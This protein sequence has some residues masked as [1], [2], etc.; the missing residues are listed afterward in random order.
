MYT[1]KDYKNTIISYD[2][3]AELQNWQKACNLLLSFLSQE[4]EVNKSLREHWQ[5]VINL[6]IS[7]A[8][9]GDPV[10]AMHHAQEAMENINRIT[11]NGDILTLDAIELC[12]SIYHS[13]GKLEHVFELYELSI[14]YAKKYFPD[15]HSILYI[16]YAKI[17]GILEDLGDFGA[18]EG[19][20]V[21][22]FKELRAL[23][24]DGV[25]EE[26]MIAVI[27]NLAGLYESMGQYSDSERFYNLALK[28]AK[29]RL[30][31]NHPEL[32]R[33]HNN[34]GYLFQSTG[35]LSHSSFH[36]GI[37]RDIFEANFGVINCSYIKASLGLSLTLFYQGDYNHSIQIANKI[38]S[39][40][41]NVNYSSISDEADAL[42]N[43]ALI[44][45]LAD[46]NTEALRLLEKSYSIEKAIYGDA[47]PILAK[48]LIQQ[49]DVHEN[50]GHYAKATKLYMQAITCLKGHEK[51]FN[52]YL[53]SAYNNIAHLYMKLNYFEKAKNMLTK[54][55][56]ISDKYQQNNSEIKIPFIINLATCN[57]QIGNIK[58]A[59]H[60][61]LNARKHITHGEGQ[62]R[63]YLYN[64]D[65]NLGSLYSKMGDISKAL[66]YS[67][68]STESTRKIFG[69]KHPLYALRLLNLGCLYYTGQDIKRSETYFREALHHIVDIRGSL[70]P[71]LP[72]Y[73]LGLA[74]IYLQT[75]RHKK[76]ISLIKKSVLISDR[77]ISSIVDIVSDRH[78]M[79]FMINQRDELDL[80]LTL[81]AEKHRVVDIELVYKT[82]LT[83]KGI[84][85]EKGSS[86]QRTL[87]T[88][89]SSLAKT[90]QAKLLNTNSKIKKLQMIANTPNRDHFSLDRITRLKDKRDNLEAQLSI[91]TSS[92]HHEQE[93]LTHY[94]NKI[95]EGIS[96][97]SIVLDFVRYSNK[98][99]SI[100]SDSKYNDI[101]YNRYGVFVLSN[102]LIDNIRFIDLGSSD[103]IDQL[104][105]GYNN[106]IAAYQNNS[107][108]D[109]LR[110]T[111]IIGSLYH[112]FG[113]RLT[114][115]LIDPIKMYID[116]HR[117]I[118]I[119]PDAELNKLSF[120][121]IPINE[122]D[123]LID[124]YTVYYAGTVRDLYRIN[125]NNKC[126][127]NRS[128]VFADP[129][130]D[131]GHHDSLFSGKETEDR[132]LN[133]LIGTKSE[134]ETISVIIGAKYWSRDKA[135]VDNLRESQSPYILHIAT[136]GY[137][138]DDQT[139]SL[140]FFEG[141]LQDI[142]EN[143]QQIVEINSTYDDPL[144]RSGLFLA[145]ANNYLKNG[146]VS[147]VL[148]GG[149]ITARDLS[150]LNY[151]GTEL[152]VLS[153]CETGLGDVQTGEGVMGLRRAFKMA[154]AKS[155]IM[156]LWKVNDSQ[157]KEIMVDFY[158]S[159]TK[160]GLGRA[161]A[162]RQ[163]QLVIKEKFP[164]PFHWG[165]WI[166]QGDPSPLPVSPKNI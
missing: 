20:Y 11:V 99:I 48:S 161:D 138:L 76:C 143:S 82:L 84:I 78:G 157:T 32:G 81:A 44:F 88:N 75:K 58:Q 111:S 114:R 15:D 146:H 18:S 3:L 30:D 86:Q 36:Y 22:A 118:I 97:D 52:S 77:T 9:L 162:L 120:A 156:S 34:V 31:E 135:S 87:F 57:M 85:T 35:K 61:L 42:A 144:V 126:K 39:Y 92:H 49:A 134:G 148:E 125:N 28:I 45:S 43:L 10:D 41:E 73:L 104:V 59:E 7:Y 108:K 110:L 133:R 128:V 51:D 155:V 24:E 131:Y 139:P 69:K 158:N 103:V 147:E 55:I 101:E 153:A 127:A 40:I 53:T 141:M 113:K 38:N 150:E 117:N 71:D 100:Q 1:I 23:L 13:I 83:R 25:F 14:K 124:S 95:L 19:A 119:S 70:H 33:L 112:K 90:I 65:N 79:Q 159:I 94:F 164:H 2:K 8:N 74:H 89:P 129:D 64:I 60:Q 62:K 56:S 96:E 67:L 26:S 166:C 91:E 109:K 132:S 145:G 136:H 80:L 47:N 116:N 154:G 98:T 63:I 93:S 4:S 130:Y 151:Q 66:E 123:Y 106:S 149:I 121:T 105:H 115:I 16:I 160:K 140:R 21:C 29:E 107:Q 68:Y 5:C 122:N 102:K 142:F 46:L 165:A 50:I 137:F 54:A 27:Q 6:A 17:A 12:V 72:K 163:A 152:V 37:A